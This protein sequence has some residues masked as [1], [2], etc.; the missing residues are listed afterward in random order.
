VKKKTFSHKNFFIN[1]YYKK[2]SLSNHFDKILNEIIQNS[3]FKTDTYHVLSNKFNFNFKINNLKKFKKFK[4]IVIV[5]MGGS[6]LGTNAIHDFLKYKIKKK[7][8]FFDNLNKEKINKFK[9][10]NNTKNCLFI[11]ISK[12]GNTIETISNFVE[13]Q[14]LKFNAK[15]IIII[16]ERKKNILSAISKKYNLPLIE[17][18]DYLG[19][20]F[21]VL[22]EVG[23]IPSYLM[24][25][26]VKKLRS[27][28][29]RYFK[30]EEKLF[31]KKSCIAL[32]QIINKKKFKSLIF[33]NY[34]P[35]LEK[36]LFWCQQ[37]IAESLGKKSRGLL[38]VISNAP[39]DHHSLLQLYL[40]GPK[41]KIF[42][43]FY[44][45]ESKGNKLKLKKIS[46]RLDF[47]H[48][49]NFEKVKKAQKNALKEAFI[50][51]KI[52]FR[53][54]RVNSTDEQ[55]LGELF[56]Y[57]I[58]ETSI[59]GKLSNL[60]PFDQPAVEQVKVFTKKLLSS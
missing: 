10:E 58:L 7:V 30:K 54:F 60:N 12:S 53:E 28:L 39:R 21:S 5:G 4:N 6:I 24:G 19:G 51:N 37:L 16:T 1:N 55:T 34:S 49:K 42:C 52:P 11:I 32:A 18:K 41:D 48:D 33:I 13:L 38:P 27:N 36:F 31:L 8:T 20:R 45:K 23:I 46:N 44:E 57:F 43:I 15:N 9:K 47:L 40:H 26:N 22:S 50:R 59:A 29:K 56:S 35:K 2:T 3:D 14:I 17:H 25:V